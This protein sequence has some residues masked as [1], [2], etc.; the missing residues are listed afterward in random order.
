[1]TCAASL[2]HAEPRQCSA[3]TGNSKTGQAGAD[4]D[5][6]VDADTIS[7]TATNCF[8]ISQ[9]G[10]AV[11][12]SPLSVFAFSQ[13]DADAFGCEKTKFSTSMSQDSPVDPLYVLDYQHDLSF[14]LLPSAGYH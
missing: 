14:S 5:A 13:K 1:M 4:V 8:H 3:S 10:C 7:N 11:Q 12:D 2:H 6:D 9:R